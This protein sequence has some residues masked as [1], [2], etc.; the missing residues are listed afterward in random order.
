MGKVKRE[1]ALPQKIR[2]MKYKVWQVP[3][4]Q[5]FKAL[6]STVIDMLQKRLK[7]GVIEPCHGPYWNFWYLVK[8]TTSR[9]F[10]LV[11]VAIELNQVTVWD[12]NLPSSADEFSEEFA[13]CAITSFIDFFS[14]YNQ[15]E[16][17]K[18]SW[19][20][21]GF[22]TPLGLMQMTTL[23]Q[24]AINSVAQFVRIVFKILAPHLRD[25]ALPFLDDIGVKS[26][27]TIY[28]NKKLASRIRRYVIE[29]IQN[30]NKVLADLEQ[31][32]VIIAEAKL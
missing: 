10:W 9:K 22:M 24:D 29:H 18:K 25:R 23:A 26:P 27:K 17:N 19:D 31:A 5:I 15:V 21:T 4:F 16:L 11:N 6:T 7:M 28:N 20:F 32:V 13:S 2:I 14:G 3:S 1:V 30:L 8:K 12:A